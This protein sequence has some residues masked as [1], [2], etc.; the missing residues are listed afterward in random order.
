MLKLDQIKTIHFTG[1]KGVAM[2]AL[3]CCAQDLG[4]TISGS[5]VKEMFVTD[6]ILK[7]RQIN[8][9]AG[10]KAEH[11]AKNLDLLVYTGAFGEQKNIEIET[12]EV[13]G[14]PTLNQAQALA[15]FIEGK[16]VISVAG[17]GG[18]STVSAMLATVFDQ[19]NTQPSFTVGVG[20][21]LGLG[22]P[23][24]LVKNSRFFIAEADEYIACKGRDCQPRFLYQN[25][26]VLVIT[27]LEY[28]HPDVYSDFE[29][30]KA[31]FVKLA[32]KV[33]NQGLVVAC[34]DNQ[35]LAEL[36]VKL[37]QPLQTYG[38]SDQADW[39]IVDWCQEN[40]AQKFN[41]RHQ[42]MLFGEISL[43]VPGRFNALNATASLVV[44]TF[45]GLGWRQ[46]QAG[47]VRFKGTKR[48]FELVF[49]S[50]NYCLYDDYAHHPREIQATLAAAKTWLRDYRLVAVF[51]PHTYSRTKALLDQ[52]SRSFTYADQL[53]LM[54]IY[55]S[56]REKDNQGISGYSLYEA[57]AK[58][59]QAVSYVDEPNKLAALI[60]ANL[61]P[62]TAVLTL[63]AGDIFLHHPAIIKVLKTNHA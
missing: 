53:I 5:D 52:F 55:A 13:R 48:R 40:R 62:K 37:D 11:L 49:K 61:K 24:R 63:G 59:H 34:L 6:P 20:E 10:F 41:V 32:A 21:I 29:A 42:G 14:V 51:Q 46:L 47:L 7:Q 1:I 54:P 9:Q 3:A 43:S 35:N 2:T 45:Y 58:Y 26:E 18:K 22:A 25:P 57:T 16:T 27:N 39:Q 44:G 31:A 28:D 12:A 60:K 38:F 30:T 33:P 17:V 50:D 23:G 36:V 8:W 15:L 19:A 4:M 56:A